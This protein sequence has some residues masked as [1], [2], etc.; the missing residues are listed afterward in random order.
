MSPQTFLP[1]HNNN[2][3]S[4]NNKTTSIVP[5]ATRKIA[6][7]SSESLT[8]TK[9][10]I[11]DTKI[12]SNIDSHSL[13]TSFD[14]QSTSLKAE[15]PLQSQQLQSQQ[16]LMQSQA[17]MSKSCLSKR[18]TTDF[19]RLDHAHIFNPLQVKTRLVINAHV[20]CLKDLLWSRSN[21]FK[22]SLKEHVF[23]S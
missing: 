5:Q 6:A 15:Q 20:F 18:L 19:R 14:V 13:S 7:V 10:E 9:S 17:L 1:V 8:A 2:N 23:I 4:S 22:L 21:T 16:S 3:N 12:P 11:P